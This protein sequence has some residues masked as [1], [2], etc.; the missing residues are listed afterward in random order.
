MKTEFQDRIDEYILDRMP[1]E[2]KELFEE[3]ISLDSSKK[4]QVE[5]TGN[6]KDAIS[7]RQQKLESIKRMERMHMQ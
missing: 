5:F 6:V 4:E 3:E 7:S 1:D 2:E